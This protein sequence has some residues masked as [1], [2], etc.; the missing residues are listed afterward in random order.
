MAHLQGARRMLITR[1]SSP[2][3]GACKAPSFDWSHLEERMDPLSI[4]ALE[5]RRLCSAAADYEPCTPRGCA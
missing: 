2:T 5:A 4:A 1:L 3:C